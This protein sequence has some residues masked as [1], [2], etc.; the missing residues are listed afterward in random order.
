[1]SY[2]PR[3]IPTKYPYPVIEA[4]ELY[5]LLGWVTTL[6]FH[7]RIRRIT[8][9][10]KGKDSKVYYLHKMT[11]VNAVSRHLLSSGWRLLNP[12][13]CVEVWRRDTGHNL[14]GGKEVNSK[15]AS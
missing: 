10:T 14:Q 5:D 11:N 8:V 4:A 7:R 9:G 3:M 2:K 15:D 13:S 6:V 12:D 1:M